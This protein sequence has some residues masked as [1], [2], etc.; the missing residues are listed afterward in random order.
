MTAVEQ[1]RLQSLTGK[2][3]KTDDH[4]SNSMPSS[5]GDFSSISTSDGHHSLSAS[6]SELPSRQSPAPASAFP[7]TRDSIPQLVMPTVMVPQRRPFSDTGRGLGKLKILVTGQSGTGKTSL[8]RAIGQTCAHIVQMDKITD[9]PNRRPSNIYASTRPSPWWK[10]HADNACKGR[11]PT[12]TDQVLDKNLCF[13]DCPALSTDNEATSPAVEYVENHLSHLSVEYIDDADLIA[14][15]SSGI[16]AN[17]DVVLYLLA[18]T[19]PTGNDVQCMRD[20]QNTTNFIPILSDI[21]GLSADEILSAKRRILCDLAAAKLDYFSF[22]PTE[23]SKDVGGIYAVNSAVT[24]DGD[25][26]D[27]SFVMDSDYLPPLV[28]TDLD[29]LVSAILSVEGSSHL[30]YAAAIKAVKWLRGKPVGG[31][32][33]ALASTR[34]LLSRGA[35]EILSNF[36]NMSREAEHRG[37]VHSTS[38]WAEGLRQSLASERLNLSQRH[39][40]QVMSSTQMTLVRP[41]CSRPPDSRCCHNWSCASSSNDQD[42]LGLLQLLR[43]FQI[44]SQLTLELLSSFGVLWCAATWLLWPK[45]PW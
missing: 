19:G 22:M 3:F 42:P 4:G 30:R 41:N 38:A 20:L 14:L 13:V 6:F 33:Y 23:S 26:V 21:D 7:E 27:A 39:T 37:Q 11:R 2:T 25:A 31:N 32:S 9:A 45:W 35:R 5:P 10:P 36:A 8:I 17:V 40:A 43:R 15:L 24:L 29:R 12:I 34:R 16:E 28:E 44:G 1:A 18:C